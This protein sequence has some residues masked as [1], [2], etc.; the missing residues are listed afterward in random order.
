MRVPGLELCFEHLVPNRPGRLKDFDYIGHHSYFITICTDQRVAAFADIEFGR[1]AISQLLTQAE[2]RGFEI[3][4]YCLMPDHVHLLIRG[5]R[6]DA[7]LKRF[8]ISW[9]TRVA[10]RWRR[11]HRTAM[12]Q[13]G[14]Y[15][16]VLRKGDDFFGMARYILRN[17]V[18]AGLVEKAE[19][20]PLSGTSGYSIEEL[21][22][23]K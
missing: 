23:E 14:Y 22:Y 15:D 11:H 17:P 7:D 13:K 6:Q 10:Y 1:W 3:T 20:Y 16:R 12:W 8:I 21:L 2:V 5:R 4:A 18:E 19:D 9:N